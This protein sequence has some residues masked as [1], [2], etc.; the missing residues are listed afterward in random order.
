MTADVIRVIG[1]ADN[2]LEFD[3]IRQFYVQGSVHKVCL[4]GVSSLA[5]YVLW[6]GATF[7]LVVPKNTGT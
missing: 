3:W 1:E 4:H 2:V 7:V 6:I 5:I